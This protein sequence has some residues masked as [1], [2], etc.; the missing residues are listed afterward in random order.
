MADALRPVLELSVQIPGVLLAYFPVK[1]YLKSS[2]LQFLGWMLSLCFCFC[3][4]GGIICY[5][6]NLPT[7]WVLAILLPLVM[8]A[9][10]KS[11]RETLWKSGSVAL[12]VCAMFACINS[13]SR[14]IDA[15]MTANLN[16]TENELWFGLS[17]GIIYNVICWFFVAMAYYPASHVARNM[18][19]DENFAQTWYVFWA[20]PTVF[21]A[22]NLFMI[23]RHRDTLYTGRV[24]QAYIVISFVL[25]AL[26]L[27]F[28]AMFLMMANSLNRNAKL[29]QENHFLSMQQKRYNSLKNAIEKARQARHDMRHHFHQ[30]SAMVENEE[31]EK[32]REYLSG[33]VSR[34]PNLDMHFCENRVADS[35]IGYYCALARRENIPFQAQI[36]L[37]EQ[38]P[39]D[40][41]DRCLV[42]SNLLENALEASLRTAEAR[43]QMKIQAY[44]HSGRLILIQVEN[45]FDGEIREK[46]EVFQSTKRKRN[47]VGI[48]S[49]RRISEESGGASTF[50]Y[51]NGVFTAKVMLCG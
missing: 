8:L 5:R 9:Y 2:P 28:Y 50:V 34:I 13:L 44:I 15:V 1:S 24:L 26:L 37:P 38:I 10:A 49:V 18:I 23:P 40:E 6:W 25:L 12:S 27:L 46:N 31:W 3:V 22:L 33:A 4:M 19:E 43:Q 48:Q 39:V 47:G 45:T 51:Q 20:L 32:V 30:I 7:I 16:S 14:A 36:Y 17:A 21:M 42:L 41:I 29:Q 35:V 11:L